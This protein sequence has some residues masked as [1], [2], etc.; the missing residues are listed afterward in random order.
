M[1]EVKLKKGQIRKKIWPRL[2]FVHTH[3]HLLERVR[4]NIK[5]TCI[6]L[7]K[8]IRVVLW[9]LPSLYNED[10]NLV[11]VRAYLP[12]VCVYGSGSQPVC[13]AVNFFQVCR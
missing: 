9:Y 11:F 4:P 2:A 12:H 8:Q 13:H 3:L 5:T 6:C 10:Q 7:Q 1:E